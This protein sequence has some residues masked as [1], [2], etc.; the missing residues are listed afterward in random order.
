MGEA[1]VN[2]FNLLTRHS[3]VYV[4]IGV[5]FN[6]KYI[7]MTM[8]PNLSDLA[9]C[10]GG[11]YSSLWMAGECAQVR[12][13][14]CEWRVPVLTAHAKGTMWGQAAVTCWGELHVWVQA[15]TTHM[16]EMQAQ[17]ATAHMR[18][19][20]YMLICFPTNCVARFQIGCSQVVDHSTGVGDPCHKILNTEIK[21]KD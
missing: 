16:R 21:S 13:T 10:R 12:I 18:E 6:L 11:G 7:H 15:A 20:L 9:A 3:C 2:H 5:Q 17:V 1:L 4:V 8:V 14:L 19:V